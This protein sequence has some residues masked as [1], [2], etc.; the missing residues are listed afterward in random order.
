MKRLRILSLIAATALLLS[1]L[2]AFEATVS[3]AEPKLIAFT[4]DDGPSDNTPRLLDGLRDLGAKATFFM[5][6]SN[7]SSGTVNHPATLKRMV[8]EGH[9]L[10]NH[11][12][13]HYVPFSE[14]SSE[15]MR[16]EE[17]LVERD[18]F[19][20]MG[21]SY[22]DFVRIPGGDDS[23]RIDYTIQAPLIFWSV[24]PLDWRDRDAD[25][26]YSRL[27]SGAH[28]GAIVLS[29]DL[30]SSTV[31]GAL[32]AI[33]DLKA[34]GYEFV[35]VAELFR[36]RG[37]TPQNG[38]LYA[39]VPNR[40]TQLPA[41][42]APT[43]SFVMDGVNLMAK[44]ANRESGLTYYYTVN[45]TVPNL[46]SHRCD[47]ERIAPGTTI[48]VVG[49]DKYGTR[50]PVTTVVA[51]LPSAA[52][53]VFDA[54]YYADRYPD[55]KAAFGY[56]E[57]RLLSHFRHSGLKEGRVASP[58]FS[59][60]EYRAAYADLQAAYGADWN[61]YVR[62]FLNH[63][64]K[65]GRRGNAQFDVTAYRSRYPDL[66]AA[67]GSDLPRYYVH[68]VRHGLAEGRQAVMDMSAYAPVFDA[69]YYADRY[70]DLKAA[71]GDNESALWRHFT[72]HGL[73]EGRRASDTFW[74]T[75]Y[76]DRYPDLQAAFGSNRLKYVE[77]YIKHGIAE[78]RTAI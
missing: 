66:Q 24:D 26:V 32:R 12:Y 18:L 7:G 37:V 56:D 53:A 45:G 28:D 61:K 42:Q 41:Y 1:L 49:I 48:Q 27:M 64:M 44:G 77:H 63:G 50:T 4:F 67:Y 43:V 14:L 74:I 65:E 36:R 76:K 34:Q 72:V 47:S 6:G 31:T 17:T 22:I 58:A 52:A 23:S 13:S 29:H 78:G 19:A 10:A 68:Y 62:H 9:Q 55:L 35:T 75:A 15:S 33:R 57:S 69:H 60:R 25:I 5:S 70:P 46:G 16:R 20:A 40:G 38:V 73:A 3:A 21:G 54:H 59:V 71:F 30:Y 8:A 2:P 11:T 39:S 51:A